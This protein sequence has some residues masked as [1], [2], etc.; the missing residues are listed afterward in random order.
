MIL[1]SDQEE[2][3]KALVKDVMN[4][5]ASGVK[6][7]VEEAPKDSSSNGLVE[8][9]VQEVQGKFRTIKSSTETKVGITIDRD[10]HSI[11]WMIR[12][13]AAKKFMAGAG[14]MVQETGREGIELVGCPEH[15]M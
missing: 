9:T 5:R 13:A 10:H 14:N 6:T 2:A 4:H 11:P 8:R 12:H 15:S 3:I 1:K 7:L